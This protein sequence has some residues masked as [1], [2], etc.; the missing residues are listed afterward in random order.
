[1]Q[2]LSFLN[3]YSGALTVIVTVI[4]VIATIAICFANLKSAKASNRQVEEMK[5]EF[6]E[7]NKPRIEVEY[8][9]EGG[10]ENRLRFVNHGEKTAQHVKIFLDPECFQNF[11]DEAFLKDLQSLHTKECIIGAGQHYDLFLGRIK[12]KGTL[13]PITGKVQYRDFTKSYESEIYVDIE[14]YV[15][16]WTSTSSS[17]LKSIVKRQN[18][19]LKGIKDELRKIEMDLREGS[20]HE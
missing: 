6:E 9:L 16:L 10:L 5:R 7:R 13:V 18:D 1:M 12:K 4:Y 15:T 3:N 11:V 2:F 20:K 17:D 8:C 14:N 19:E